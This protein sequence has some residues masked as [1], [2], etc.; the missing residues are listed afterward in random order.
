MVSQFS[1]VAQSCLTLCDP[2]L[3]K[4]SCVCIGKEHSTY[5]FGT[6]LGFR[7]LQGLGTAL[8][9]I[10]MYKRAIIVWLVSHV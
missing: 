6:T 1:S 3:Y 8:E 2:I 4:L 7:H 10:P 5:R 9:K